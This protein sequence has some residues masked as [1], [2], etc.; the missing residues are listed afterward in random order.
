MTRSP[1]IAH[2]ARTRAAAV[3]AIAMAL[4]ST[5][6]GIL[7]KLP[8]APIP[9]KSPLAVVDRVE[10]VDR[11]DEAARYLIYVTL[12]NPNDVALP[13]TEAHYRLSV[14]EASAD[15]YKSDVTPNA[16]LPADGAIQ[17]RLPAVL[18]AGPQ[19]GEFEVGGSIRVYPPGQIKKVGYD[20]GWPRPTVSFSGKGALVTNLG[21]DLEVDFQAPEGIEGETITPTDPRRESDAPARRPDTEPDTPG[22]TID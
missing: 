21:A 11:S 10:V 14:A 1:S 5:G 7:I 6:C 4:G 8:E 16:T 9:I 3:A 2:P 12:T 15:G 13:M 17:V 22:R 18:A 19:D 20:L